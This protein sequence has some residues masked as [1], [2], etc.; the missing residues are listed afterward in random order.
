MA[1]A[2]AYQD[3]KMPFD[4]SDKYAAKVNLLKE[5]VVEAEKKLAAIGGQG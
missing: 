3:C 4:L 5:W 2:W 1:A